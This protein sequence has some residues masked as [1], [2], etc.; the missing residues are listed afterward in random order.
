MDMKN[1]LVKFTNSGGGKD[2]NGVE[3]DLTWKD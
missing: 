1:K 3:V 2:Q